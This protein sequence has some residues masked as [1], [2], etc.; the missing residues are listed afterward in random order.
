MCGLEALLFPRL[1][2]GYLRIE[3]SIGLNLLGEA[4]LQEC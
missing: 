3:H 2:M 4:E 1:N